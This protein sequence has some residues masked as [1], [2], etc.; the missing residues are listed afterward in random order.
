MNVTKNVEKWQLD[1]FGKRMIFQG[2]CVVG[3]GLGPSRSFIERSTVGTENKRRS[4]TT[5]TTPS[6]RRCTRT[7]CTR[8]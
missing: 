2:R 5:S 6:W 3:L 1:E 7:A 8:R 4:A